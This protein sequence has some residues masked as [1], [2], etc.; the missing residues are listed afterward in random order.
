M[1]YWY[2]YVIGLTA[3]F[4]IQ[5]FNRTAKLYFE[6]GQTLSWNELVTMGFEPMRIAPADLKPA[7]LTTRPYH[8]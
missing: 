5:C 8:H 6:S 7:A 1:E 3:F 2:P 4:Y